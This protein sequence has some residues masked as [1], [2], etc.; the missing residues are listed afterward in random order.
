MFNAT[1]NHKDY[2][3]LRHL[4][5]SFIR[6]LQT[7]QA[8]NLRFLRNKKAKL[9]GYHFCMNTNIYGNFQTCV[10]AFLMWAL[11]QTTNFS[12]N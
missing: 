4:K 8:N 11:L 2:I 9:S 12:Y 10:S 7:S 3:Q 1:K 5:I 6:Y